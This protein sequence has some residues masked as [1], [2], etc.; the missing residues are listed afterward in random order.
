MK[1]FCCMSLSPSFCD[2][3]IG[4][5]SGFLETNCWPLPTLS[6]KMKASASLA[7]MSTSVIREMND[8]VVPAGLKPED[9]E[10][11]CVTPGSTRCIFENREGCGNGSYGIVYFLNEGYKGGEL[12]FSDGTE[13]LAGQVGEAVVW[14]HDEDL[15]LIAAPVE[16]GLMFV[17]VHWMRS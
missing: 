7:L 4:G 14:E 13:L 9:C 16:S 12:S 11:I 3:I 1:Y 15:E 6:H 2:Q 5:Y 10:L 17:L 8:G